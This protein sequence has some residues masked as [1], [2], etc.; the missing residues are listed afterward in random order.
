MIAS[1]PSLALAALLGLCATATAH[2]VAAEG[3]E[4]APVEQI[5]PDPHAVQ[6]GSGRHRYQFVLRDTVSAAPAAMRPFALSH[7]QFNLPF[8]HEEKDVYLGITD[9]QGRTPV[10]AFEQAPPA[11][12]WVL[13]ERF[14]SG[15]YGERM[16]LQD[17]QGEGVGVMAYEMVVCGKTPRLYRGVTNAHGDTAYVATSAIVDLMLFLDGDSTFGGGEKVAGR[18]EPDDGLT[19]LKRCRPAPTTTE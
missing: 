3:V 8:V 13:L 11:Q 15:P 18:I 9:A 4:S 10:F 17:G 12:G 5:R 16:R 1:K 19:A 14:G 2:P 7:T 6:V